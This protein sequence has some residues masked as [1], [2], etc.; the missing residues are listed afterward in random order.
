M[1]RSRALQLTQLPLRM[2]QM[3]SVR[4]PPRLLAPLLAQLPR[5]EKALVPL[6]R[7]LQQQPAVQARQLLLAPVQ[8]PPQPLP[9][10]VPLRWLQP[11][12]AQLA[13]L[14]QQLPVQVWVPW[15]RHPL[16]LLLQPPVLVQVRTLPAQW[17]P[18]PRP[19]L[20]PQRRTLKTQ[21]RDCQSGWAACCRWV[22]RRLV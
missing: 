14:L 7:W 16:L 21:G 5:Q 3:G 15:L 20:G 13:K 2:L 17:Q 18:A 8:P 6:Q 10:L 4:L 12:Q 9:L 1:Q 11:R 22:W 19:L